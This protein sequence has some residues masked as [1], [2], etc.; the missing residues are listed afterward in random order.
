MDERTRVDAA[1]DR[2]GRA[3]SSVIGVVLV[4]SLVLAGTAAVV[5]L[6]AAALSDTQARSELERAEHSMTL[7]NS[8][9]SMVALGDSPAQSLSFGQ[10]SG[11]LSSDPDAGWIRI[12]HVDFDGS[13]TD[14]TVLNESLGAVVYA[15]GDTELVY[16]GGGVWR[17]DRQGDAMMVS[18]PEF[19]YRGATLTLPIVRIENEAHASAGATARITSSADT[20]RVFPNTTTTGG[21]EI[22]APYN[23]T[24]DPYVNPVAN[25]TV[26]VTVH[27]EYYEGWA[28]YFR[29]RTNGEVKVFPNDER[30]RVALVSLA[31]SIGPFNMPAEGNSLEVRGMGDDHPITSYDLTLAADNHINNMHW[32][33]YA[34]EGNE[35]FEL[36]FYSNDKCKSGSYDGELDVSIYYYNSSGASTIHEEWQVQA[37]DPDTNAD[38]AVDCSTNE[39]SIDLV[40]S[41]DT[42][43][44]YDDIALTG[45]N[46]KWLFGPE[47]DS[48]D[49][50]ASTTS[51]GDHG[52]EDPQASYS[53][54]ESEDL[55]VLVN[56]YLQLL[57]PQYDLTV[58]D[59]PGGSSRI[60]E[61]ASDGTLEFDTSGN[62]RYITYLHIT[63]NE[64]SVDLG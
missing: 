20:R 48:R 40:D 1:D 41:T 57:G 56:H 47:I 33:F 13:G 9:A 63:E 51:F 38:F 24:S 64:V 3:Q 26:N 32:S 39:L 42:T 6:G 34:D 31:G 2:R 19:H 60:D 15:N 30:V 27:S 14:E 53:T 62:G 25:G 4:L 23:G 22:G 44:T 5:T 59:G 37:I 21:T 18:P 17:Q 49:V 61:G 43:L 29:T 8:R 52:G 12:T 36:H 50:D 7:F 16:Q 54:G 28:E 11:Q 55:D 58:T 45:S 10:D 35:Q 46:N